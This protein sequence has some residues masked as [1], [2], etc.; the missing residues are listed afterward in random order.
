MYCSFCLDAPEAHKYKTNQPAR[1][2]LLKYCGR[3][4]NQEGIN[5]DYALEILLHLETTSKYG[6]SLHFSVYHSG[7]M[8]K[9]RKCHILLYFQ[10]SLQSSIT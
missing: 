7:A 10:P 6:A 4:E 9:L 2:L 1:L 3:R 5:P 8:L